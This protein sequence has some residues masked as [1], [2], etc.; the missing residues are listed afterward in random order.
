ELAKSLKNNLELLKNY[1]GLS[2]EITLGE[3]IQ[4]REITLIEE[5]EEE[6][7]VLWE[8]IRPAL[9]EALFE[10]KNSR[11][12]EGALLKEKILEYL[13]FLQRKVEEISALKDKIKAENINK[14]KIRIEKLLEEFKGSLEESRLYQELAFL[15]DKMDFS[16]ELERFII[17]LKS[18]KELIEVPNSG[19]RLDFI[20]QELMR[21]INT[22]SNKAQSAEISLIAV[23]IKDYIEK[24]REQLQNVV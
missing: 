5:K 22:L 9:E 3:I 16:E 1:L 20:C 11:L 13:F 10:L 8:E 17:H 7:E 18:F 14:F 24:I 2:G 12:R 21:E 15:L 19:K 4:F 6:I 23:E